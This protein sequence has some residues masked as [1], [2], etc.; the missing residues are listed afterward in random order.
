MV[1]YIMFKIKYYL[2]E[3]IVKTLLFLTPKWSVK[4]YDYKCLL[5][6]IYDEGYIETI[7]KQT[8]RNWD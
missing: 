6:D 2:A 3:Y 7:C 1:K 5:N 4:H 8:N